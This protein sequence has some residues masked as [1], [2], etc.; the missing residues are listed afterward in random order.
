MLVDFKRN[1]S[2]F[3]WFHPP[4]KTSPEKKEKEEFDKIW[5]FSQKCASNMKVFFRKKKN[6]KNFLLFSLNYKKHTV[7][8]FVNPKCIERRV[9]LKS[10]L[11]NCK[12]HS[13]ISS[14]M[15]LTYTFDT[16]ITRQLTVIR[17]V[18]CTRFWLHTIEWMRNFTLF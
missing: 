13:L 8:F 5:K 14:N 7:L 3:H 4:Q 17:L 12:W 18:A 16:Y 1:P 15:T 11:M 9:K 10:I 2:Y 6:F